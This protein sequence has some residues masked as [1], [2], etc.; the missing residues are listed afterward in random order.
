MRAV[1][2]LAAIETLGF[3]VRAPRPP[4]KKNVFIFD[5]FAHKLTPEG[6]R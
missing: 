6:A 1:D 4:A 2:V 3:A 5:F